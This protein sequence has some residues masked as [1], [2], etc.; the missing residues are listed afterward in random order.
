MQNLQD[1]IMAWL[2]PYEAGL[3]PLAQK[4]RPIN[5]N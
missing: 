5:A 4:E 3:R 2:K 1:T